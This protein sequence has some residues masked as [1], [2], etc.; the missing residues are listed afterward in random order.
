MYAYA[1]FRYFF[2]SFYA[3]RCKI[4][5]VTKVYVDFFLKHSFS[6]CF[7]F[8][9]V[10]QRRHY[11]GVWSALGVLAAS[12]VVLLG[13]RLLIMGALP[14][15]FAPA[16]NPAADCDSTF[17]RALTFFFLPAFNFWLLLCPSTL[18]FDWSMEA[19]PLVRNLADARNLISLLF[20]GWLAAL[21]L[22]Y[23][24]G[25]K[26][27]W[28]SPGPVMSRRWSLE[29]AS[30][31][32]G[33]DVVILGLALLVLPF[34]PATNL[35][36]YVGFVVAERILYIPSMGF[37]LLVSWGIHVLH[38][39]SKSTRA[40]RLLYAAVVALLVLL[41]ARTWTRNQDW[42]TEE[43]LYRSGIPIN[44]PKGECYVLVL[45][46]SIQDIQLDFFFVEILKDK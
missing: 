45:L 24:T 46:K 30:T 22:T 16:D 26:K 41:A 38:V 6:K 13:G 25:W 8:F 37:C 20:Y 31:S 15:E 23:L 21:G 40:R 34:L 9:I 2:Q 5:I 17:V 7:F 42:A 18:S 28:S 39:R 14:P 4:F 32:S 27:S 12:A 36:F 35:F 11:S 43:N 29:E 1:L 44:P 33:D 10:L 3:K 19:V